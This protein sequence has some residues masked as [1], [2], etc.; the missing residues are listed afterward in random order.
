MVIKVLCI[1]A[2]GR[3]NAHPTIRSEVE[4]IGEERNSS[5]HHLSLFAR[6]GFA[7]LWEMAAEKIWN[8]LEHGLQVIWQEK[9][10]EFYWEPCWR[11]ASL[12]M[13]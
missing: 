11:I 7:R 8:E 4:S 6:L 1:E 13:K 3:G 2:F 9:K 10:R 5:N 12:G